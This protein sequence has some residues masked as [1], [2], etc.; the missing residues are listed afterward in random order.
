[1]PASNAAS[2]PA[3]NPSTGLFVIMSPFSGP[4]GSVL[5]AKTIDSW[6][7]GTPVYA[8]NEDDLSTGALNT[9]IGFGANHIFDAPK[10][11]ALPAAGFMDDY[12]PGET[13]PSGVAATDSRLSAIG[14]GRSGPTVDGI[15][16]TLPFTAGFTLL[17]FGAGGS[18]D[19]G[20]GPIFTG[21]E[22]KTV[23]AAGPV[24][25]G[26]AIE[27]GYVNRTGLSMISGLSAFGSSVNASDEPA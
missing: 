18:R 8:A 21:F 11:T 26:A 3:A 22:I 20:A 15:A 19:A 12:I 4:K 1:M 5:D 10:T 13:L 14:G 6:S 2:T 9:G 27:A 23:T 7:G 16:P 25:P 24:A 17:G